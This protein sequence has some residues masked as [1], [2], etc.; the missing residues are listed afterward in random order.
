M[1]YLIVKTGKQKGAVFELKTRSA[2][3]GRDIS[4][5]V[6]VMDQGASRKHAEIFK[7]G[8]FWV[9]RDLGSTNGV[10][11]NG[12][13]IT[14]EILHDNN[15]ILIGSTVLLF[16]SSSESA[17][18]LEQTPPK[19]QLDQ[20]ESTIAMHPSKSSDTSRYK[21]EIENNPLIKC[22]GAAVDQFPK[23]VGS[24]PYIQAVVSI[25]ADTLEECYVSAVKVIGTNVDAV[26]TSS[27]DA[28]AH[29]SYRVVSHAAKLSDAVLSANAA[30]DPRFLY[31][32]SIL[33]KRIKSVL[34]C[35]VQHEKA[36]WGTLYVCSGE[37][38]R[39]NSAHLSL[40]KS[41]SAAVEFRLADGTRRFNSPIEAQIELILYMFEK[42]G[43]DVDTHSR[44]VA[45]LSREVCTE[46]KISTHET[47]NV[48]H[49]A[50]LHDIGKLLL[51]VSH[52]AADFESLANPIHCLAGGYFAQNTE[53]MKHLAGFIK[54]HNER[55]D[56]SG[57]PLGMKA[58]TIPLAAKILITCNAFDT[59]H[60]KIVDIN[61]AMRQMKLD[62]G[63]KF[64]KRVVASL[65][66][67]VGR[68]IK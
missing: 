22:F 14:E 58:E 27:P 59:L 37:D 67:V 55:D 26:A 46:M 10:F 13:K 62:A 20:L 54:M 29:V 40:L 25:L 38:N 2:I 16:N 33:I 65:E 51:Y 17:V 8:D 44:R 35:P 39:F 18:R 49:A 1:A 24:E 36:V 21:Y 3:L 61:E 9:V 6:C 50:L 66:T 4:N 63:T 52:G 19:E 56:G 31:S 47:L 7:L 32:E 48:Y 64:D 12:K 43:K 23:T 34:C 11:V 53:Y 5:D 41:L 45:N 68:Q 57:L 60:S 15:E 28:K 30:N 42:Q